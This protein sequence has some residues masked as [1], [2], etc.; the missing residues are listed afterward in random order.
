MP[1]PNINNVVLTGQLTYDPELRVLPS[2]ASVCNLRVAV[3]A[4]RRNPAGEW[5]HKP[6]F[7]EVAVYGPHAETVAKYCR[8]G[9]PIAVD[10]R[11]DWREWETK[12]DHRKVQA[13]R[14]IARSVQFLGS[15]PSGD[16]NGPAEDGAGGLHG[17]AADEEEIL[18]LVEEDAIGIAA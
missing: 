18:E 15:A 8:K 17:V 4:R 5:G 6:N 10:G 2:G 7:F 9:H 1:V 12:D 14:I 13:V 16:A 3:N 11:L